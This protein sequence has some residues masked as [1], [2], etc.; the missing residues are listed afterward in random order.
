MYLTFSSLPVLYYIGTNCCKAA[1]DNYKQNMI[2]YAI[3]QAIMEDQDILL[4]DE[5]FN[6]SDVDSVENIR[7]EIM[8]SSNLFGLDKGNFE[9]VII[10]KDGLSVS[11]VGGPH[12]RNNF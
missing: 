1:A 12:L 11:L 9:E 4:L 6:G 3:A 10:Y 7:E 8:E 5:P 2:L